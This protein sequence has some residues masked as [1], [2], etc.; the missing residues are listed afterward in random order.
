MLNRTL[1][2][3][4]V[5]RILLLGAVLCATWPGGVA[6]AEDTT[7]TIMAQYRQD[8]PVIYDGAAAD[9]PTLDPQ[10]ASDS[11]SIGAIE[12]LYEGLTDFDPSNNQIIPRMAV[13]WETSND[14]LTWTFN[15]RNDVMWYQYNPPTDTAQAMRPVV[16]GDFQYAIQRL[17]DPRL[18]SFYGTVFATVLA[19]CEVVNRTPIDE[20]TD[21]LVF[22]ET[23][24]VFV[25]DDQTLVIKLQY[26]ASYFLSMS[27]MWSLFPVYRE[28]IEQYGDEWTAPG[29]MVTHGPFF[30]KESIRGVGKIYV[31]NPDFPA[32]L[33]YGGNIDIVRLT[34]IEDGGTVFAL[35][36]DKQLDKAG[37]PEAEYE[38][39][40]QNPAFQNQI[41]LQFTTSVYY[42]GF[43]YIAPFDNVHIRRAFSAVIDREA[44]IA[45]N[46]SGRDLPMIHFTP[47]GIAHAP[48]I[49]EVGVGFDPEYARAEMAAA[50]YP[51]CEG[52]PPT[53]IVTFQ[54]AESWGA[55]L[56]AAAEE[57][58]GCDG[59]LFEIDA[60]EFATL[61]DAIHPNTTPDNRPEIWTLGWAADYP[62]AHNY[63]HDVLACTVANQMPRICTEVDDLIEKATGETDYLVRNDLYRQ[64]EEA[65]F[66]YGGE[67]P[68]APVLLGIAHYLAQP[69]LTGPFETRVFGLSGIDPFSIDTAAKLAARGQ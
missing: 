45:Q 17:C 14:G 37:I 2:Y 47:P 54:G 26:A 62:D 52:F 18:G 8:V 49:N 61:L 40:L 28:A 23:L 33:R 66:G 59:T 13:S 43:S 69:W 4:I 41:H 55:F 50:G 58:L 56:A 15:L 21:D 68:I 60:L 35:Y 1:H 27:A 39:V 29:N 19:G 32:D 16:A 25:P 22:G 5:A 46:R 11:A 20:V 42:Y 48:P 10:I 51:N 67:F 36:L 64:I 57:Y 53:Q 6:M 9:E 63:V 24:Q 30:L 12:G 3:M 38:Q 44:F 7:V 65:F 34:L 31:R